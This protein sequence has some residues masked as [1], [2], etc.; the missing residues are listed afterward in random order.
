MSNVQDITRELEEQQGLLDAESAALVA[1]LNKATDGLGV[2]L[3][4]NY[5]RLRSRVDLLAAA[6][7]ELI[8]N[9]RT[10]L[11]G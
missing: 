6:R 1:A 10:E 4:A 3:L 5:E 2:R 9:G 7:S 11:L 8:A